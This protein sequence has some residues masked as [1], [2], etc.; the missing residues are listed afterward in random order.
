MRLAKI[1]YPFAAK[2]SHL[3]VPHFALDTFKEYLTASILNSLTINDVEFNPVLKVKGTEL[4]T[5]EGAIFIGA[6]FYLNFIFMRHLYDIGRQPTVFLLTGTDE[7]R[8]LGTKIPFEI[9]SN[10]PM[11]LNYVRHLTS[12]GKIVA[13]VIDYNL[14]L[15]NWKKLNCSD[16]D[17]Y[18]NDSLIKLAERTKTPVFFFD[19]YF[20]EKDNIVSSVVKTTSNETSVVLDEFADFI[21]SAINR[22]K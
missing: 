22:R 10:K 8:I 21:S 16:V 19:T 12:R 18:V 14:P 5:P 2:F 11:S 6:H 9:I 17:L 13:A 20:D 1:I 7:W 4:I 15:P 3:T